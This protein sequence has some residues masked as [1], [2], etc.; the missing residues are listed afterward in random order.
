MA[1]KGK[2]V[3][4]EPVLRLEISGPGVRPGRIT[5]PD[6]VRICEQVQAAVNRQAEAL[7]GKASLRPGPFTAKTKVECT[8]DIVGIRNG[9]TVLPFAIAK[10]QMPLPNVVVLGEQA[11]LELATAIESL[12]LGKQRDWDPGVLDSLNNL[13]SVFEKNTINRI[14]FVVP[15]AVAKKR[16][17][18]VPFTPKVRERVAAQMKNP[19]EREAAAE[20][21]LEMADFKPGDH[22]C[23]INTPLGSPILGLFS[24]ALESAIQENL[25]RAVRVN[26]KATI[27][28]HSGRIE[29]MQIGAIEPIESFSVG[30]DEFFIARSFADLAAIQEVKPLSDIKTLAG[31]FSQS[32]NVDEMLDE[33]YRERK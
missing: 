30:R 19:T 3:E 7:E 14:D 23:R 9:S 8:L 13:G 4:E 24:D 29:V 26:G 25:R 2:R 31:V 22:K 28:P 1:S 16:M 27:N 33:I 11:V 20:G 32:E 17:M 15:R 10:S 18:R 21:V 12:A 6:L 5:V